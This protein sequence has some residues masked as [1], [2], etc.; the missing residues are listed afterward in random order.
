MKAGE[1]DN[2]EWQATPQEEDGRWTL[3][4]M[5]W[6]PEGRN[7]QKAKRKDEIKK[8]VKQRHPRDHSGWMVLAKKQDLWKKFRGDPAKS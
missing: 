7:G 6:N 3:E 4:V 2:G 5:P 1:I 8:F